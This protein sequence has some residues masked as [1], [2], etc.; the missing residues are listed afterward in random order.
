MSTAPHMQ[1]VRAIAS[2]T[3]VAARSSSCPEV[4]ENYGLPAFWATQATAHFHNA[5]V[6]SWMHLG[7]FTAQLVA[8]ATMC[9]LLTR[10]AA[11]CSKLIL[12]EQ[13]RSCTY[14]QVCQ[15]RLF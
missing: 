12:A 8:V 10:A 6:W 2:R 9:V 14:L 11:L 5:A 7:I 15:T 13:K 1:A 4:G 3:L